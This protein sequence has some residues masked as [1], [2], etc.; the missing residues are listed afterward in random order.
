MQF[1]VSDPYLNEKIALL[2]EST[3]HGEPWSGSWASMM[4]SSGTE[5]DDEH[6]TLSACCL[7]FDFDGMRADSGQQI[8]AN[9]RQKVGFGMS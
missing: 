3:I 6:A 1:D 7:F 8:Y 9:L 2:I 5:G 4:L